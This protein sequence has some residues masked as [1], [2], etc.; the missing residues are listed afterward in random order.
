MDICE[1]SCC[2]SFCV[3]LDLGDFGLFLFSYCLLAFETF[4]KSHG[5]LRP[6]AGHFC[7]YI[8]F[9]RVFILRGCISIKAAPNSKTACIYNH[10]DTQVSI[11][12]YHLFK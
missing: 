11:F 4:M 7:K 8:I 3:D 9:Y 6:S 12:D 5:T 1:I 10:L 2:V